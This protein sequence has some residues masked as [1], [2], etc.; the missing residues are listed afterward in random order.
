[1][2]NYRIIILYCLYSKTLSGLSTKR[3][4]K[5]ILITF[6]KLFDHSSSFGCECGRDPNNQH[7]NAYKVAEKTKWNVQQRIVGEILIL[8]KDDIRKEKWSK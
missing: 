3:W 2:I 6:N 1:M 5:I 7:Q 8:R 4:K